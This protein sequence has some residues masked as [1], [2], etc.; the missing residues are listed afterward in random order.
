MLEFILTNQNGSCNLELGFFTIGGEIL[1]TKIRE[2]LPFIFMLIIICSLSFVCSILT[3]EA[4][5]DRSSQHCQELC[6]LLIISTPFLMGLGGFGAAFTTVMVYR[7]LPIFNRR[8][9]MLS[10]AILL[11]FILGVLLF[12]VSF[13]IIEQ[14][15]VIDFFLNLVREVRY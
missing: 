12:I 3:Y 5:R 2:L 11:C 15:Q 14:K 10:L 7:D 1:E 8:P 6:T 4:T 9:W 13:V